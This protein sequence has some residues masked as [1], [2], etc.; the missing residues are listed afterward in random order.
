M[1]S[2]I[3]KYRNNPPN[4]YINN[5]F[6][7]CPIKICQYIDNTDI[8]WDSIVD[9]GCGQGIK[10]LS[11]ALMY[12]DKEIVGIDITNAFRQAKEFALEKLLLSKLPNN[13]HFYQIQP[14]QNLKTILKTNVDIVYSW[15]VLEHVKKGLLP[16]IIQD[17]YD[18]L[19]DLGIVFTQIAPL[20]FSPHGSHLK[21]YV[22]SPWAHLQ[23]SHSELRE[24]VEHKGNLGLSPDQINKRKWMFNNYERLNKLTAV[25]LSNYF[26]DTGFIFKHK[27]VKKVSNK[28]PQ[29]LLD[30]Y[31]EK[32]LTNHEIIY[33][34]QKSVA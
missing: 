31:G 23:L 33:I 17:M 3:E 18:S 28:P 1:S 20:Y 4:Q 13:L 26:T 24:L 11:I 16:N 25:E 27:E 15:S 30:I 2:Q 19:N 32:L 12:P 22:S 14:G 6:N 5:Q 8:R 9:F 21:D 10:T 7:I 29:N 34:V